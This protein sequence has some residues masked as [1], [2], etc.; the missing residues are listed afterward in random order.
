MTDK[1]RWGILGTGA[2]ASKF[3]A[4]L[5]ESKLGRLV[6]VASRGRDTAD[7]FATEVLSGLSIA[8]YDR[9]E[10]L[11]ADKAVDAVYIATPHP[12]HARWAIAAAQAGKHILC[13]KPLAMNKSQAEQMIDAA[14]KYRVFLMEA[15]MYRCHPMMTELRGLLRQGAIGQVRMIHANFGFRC[16]VDDNHRLLNHA[17]GGGG[18][19]DVGCYPI[20]LA[21]WVAGVA[22]DRD[23]LDPTNVTAAANIGVHS[24]VD[25]MASALLTFPNEILA[26]VTA[27][28][29][30]DL[31]NAV[32]IAGS[33]GRIEVPWLWVPKRY[34][35]QIIIHRPN[36]ESKTLTIDAPADVYT[37]EAD[38]AAA[39]I[40]N[41]LQEPPTPAMNW[42]DTLG[43]MQTLDLWRQAIGLKYDYADEA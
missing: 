35:N 24:G 30:C 17:L 1:L 6:A 43:N 7:A 20:S 3:A 34:A 12:F 36:G 38:V 15:F 26:S 19:L 27:A 42:A 39:A 21:R 9:Y 11:L 14:R 10:S 18:I 31:E 32:H 29:R 13:E 22:A 40:A 16:V 2:I 8:R 23:F 33:E 25:E 28:L 37:L 5:M 41:G 4:G